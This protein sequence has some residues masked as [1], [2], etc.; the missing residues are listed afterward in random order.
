[1]VVNV[2]NFPLVR[3]DQVKFEYSVLIIELQVDV[4]YLFKRKK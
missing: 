3:K 1:M 4:S 2:E